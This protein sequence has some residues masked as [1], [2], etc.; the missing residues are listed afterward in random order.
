VLRPQQHIHGVF[1][2]ETETEVKPKQ[3]PKKRAVLVSDNPP[4]EKEVMD[5]ILERCEKEYKTLVNPIGAETQA[6]LYYSI[7]TGNNWIKQG[8][9]GDPVK[10]WKLDAGQ[11]VLSKQKDICSNYNRAPEPTG[12]Q[13]RNAE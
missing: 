7:R 13:W 6:K 11:W 2:S 4:S 5:Y 3:K 9:H 10:N 1:T 8:G 12:T